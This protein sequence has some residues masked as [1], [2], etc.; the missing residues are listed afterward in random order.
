VSL[1]ARH[2]EA[3]GIPTVI[4][5]QQNRTLS[6]LF[7]KRS[8]RSYGLEVLLRR[9]ESDRLFGWVS[10]SILRSERKD[11]PSLRWRV[12]DYDQSHV[13]TALGSY[14]LGKGF[15]VG[16][17]FRFATGFAATATD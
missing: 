3:N 5:G 4:M 9:R 1:A 2:L 8:G 11:A 7:T 15:E 14:D 16:L 6:A 13:F 12:F 17:R 10:Y